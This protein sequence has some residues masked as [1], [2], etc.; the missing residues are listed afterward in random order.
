MAI[1]FSCPGCG[2][3]Y[4]ASDEFAGKK[5]RCKACQGVVPIPSGDEPDLYGLDDPPPLPPPRLGFGPRPSMAEPPRMVSAGRGS[6][7][8]SFFSGSIWV[9][10]FAGVC[11]LSLTTRIVTGLIRLN[12]GPDAPGAAAA[13]PMNPAGPMNGRVGGYQPRPRMP[14]APPVMPPLG[15]GRPVEPGVVLHEVRLGMSSTTPPVP[16]QRGKLWVYLPADATAPASVPCVFMCGA[17]SKLIFG[18]DLGEGD[19]PEHLPYVR[20]GFAV[21][22]YELDGA[23]PEGAR[24]AVPSFVVEASMSFLAAESGLVNARNAIA[25]AL[26]KVPQVD[27]N[28]L[29]T[30][31]H[32]SAGT[33]ALLLAENEPRLKG[34]A[35]YAPRVDTEAN[36]PA[37]ARAALIQLVPAAREFW[38]RFN[39]IR[40]EGQLN[41]PVFLFY[42]QGDTVIP[43]AEIIGCAGRLKGLG[44]PVTLETVPGGDHYRSMIEVGLPKGVE[45][46]AGLAGLP[47]KPT[48]P[49]P[50]TAPR[51]ASLG[52]RANGP[53]GFGPPPG[54][55]RG[56]APRPPIRSRARMPGRPVA[57]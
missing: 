48:Q 31:G 27:P 20:A 11:I 39:P 55:R 30:A 10:V 2:K 1:T 47:L 14:V 37:P 43:S 36:A 38:D 7:G 5:M 21:V 3:S 51:P 16:G 17:G 56:P 44:K 45:W 35:A 4:T 24:A 28:R 53:V 46:L 52:P 6:S 26:E 41:C 8:K 22:A 32:S 54:I 15:G 9:N 18:M 57:P 33:M 49:P 12:R 34:V 23:E 42:A 25:Y 13:G 40:H 29:Y 19:R 50:A